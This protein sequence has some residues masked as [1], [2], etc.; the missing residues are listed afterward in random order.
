MAAP[1][2]SKAWPPVRF[3][4]AYLQRIGKCLT[5]GCNPEQT[6]VAASIVRDITERSHYLNAAA[7]LHL[8]RPDLVVDRLRVP[9][10]PLSPYQVDRRTQETGVDTRPNWQEQAQSSAILAALAEKG[11]PQL[12]RYAQET[13][14]AEFQSD[15]A[16]YINSSYMDG[17]FR[18]YSSNVQVFKIP[19]FP[20]TVSVYGRFALANGR[21]KTFQIVQTIWSH[22]RMVPLGVVTSALRPHIAGARPWLPHI[23]RLVGETKEQAEEAGAELRDIANRITWLEKQTWDRADA[24][25]DMGAA[26]K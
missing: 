11:L 15:W 22:S 23:R 1:A 26:K 20:D 25:E 13:A 5:F 24:V 17:G 3:V 10:N 21:V 18:L 16:S 9:A 7:Q 6:R 19:Q 14:P 2:A 4:P 8:M 12:L